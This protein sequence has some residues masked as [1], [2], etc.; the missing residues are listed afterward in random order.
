MEP[1]IGAGAR[2]PRTGRGALYAALAA[3]AVAL[4]V[5]LW[6]AVGPDG[7]APAGTP[8]TDADAAGAPAGAQRPSGRDALVDNPLYRTGR[9]SPLPCPAPGLHVEDPD[10][11][12][13]FLNALADCLDYA[14]EAQFAKA[15]L[16]YRPPSRVF[17]R[18][19]GTSPCRDYPSEAGAFYCRTS[20]SIYIGTEDVVSKWKG[21]PNGIVY[22]SLLAHEYAH[23]V[24]GE[25]G[26]LEY[27]HQQRGSQQDRSAQNSWTRRAELQANCLAGA[28]L[29]SIRV[30]YGLTSDDIALMMEDAEAT[31]DRPGG[32]DS[33]RTHGSAHN[34]RTWLRHGFD[35]QTPRACNTWVADADLVS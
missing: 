17:W 28:F 33:D 31:A 32:P 34:S 14:W 21:E 10:S 7:G 3:V 19:P 15:E 16:P 18:E 35:E 11:V 9:L 24:Q 29:G 6:S 12:E 22:A 13:R 5:L 23:H 8:E 30:S 4:T 20:T 1:G 27:Y 2:R 25:S 26:L